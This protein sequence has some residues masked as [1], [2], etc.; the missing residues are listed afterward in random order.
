MAALGF[1]SGSSQGEKRAK[2]MHTVSA[3]RGQVG[4]QQGTDLPGDRAVCRGIE[5]GSPGL[6]RGSQVSTGPRSKLRWQWLCNE[7]SEAP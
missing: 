6:H 4:N 1:L 2:P 3:G 7:R 5:P